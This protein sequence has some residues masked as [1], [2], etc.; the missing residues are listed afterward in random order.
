MKV[1]FFPKR[2]L[3]FEKT[4]SDEAVG[5]GVRSGQ[6]PQ[7]QSMQMGTWNHEDKS[8]GNETTGIGRLRRTPHPFLPSQWNVLTH[9][10]IPILTTTPRILSPATD[11]GLIYRAAYS[12]SI[13]SYLSILPSLFLLDP[14]IDS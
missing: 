14:K 5:Q 9:T 2:V 3:G 13:W 12:L 1:C 10:Q 8:R 6:Y 4:D 7:Q 11:H